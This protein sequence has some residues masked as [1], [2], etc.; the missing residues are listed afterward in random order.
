MISI[1]VPTYNA[2]RYLRQAVESILEQDYLDVELIVVDGK[3]TD[4]TVNIL[5]EYGKEIRWI[6]EKDKGE[7]DAINKGM[8]MA[9]GELIGFLNADDIY[10]PN[11]LSTV[12]EHFKDYPNSMWAY[13]KC[14][15]IDEDGEEARG[16]VTKIKELFQPHY[17]YS[18]LL[19]GDFIAQPAAFWRREL[20][21]EIG[22]FDIRETLAF[23]YDFWLRAGKLYRPGFINEYLAS[24]R[25]HSES[26][27]VNN[28]YKDMKDAYR[29]SKGYSLARPLINLA[30]LGVYLATTSGYFAMN[31]LARTRR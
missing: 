31:T 7:P 30:Q 17:S 12:V 4:S 10:L 29:I 23:E 3:S 19:I 9:K 15:I 25:A 2:E 8:A 21:N 5:R 27:T 13:G 20:V 24:W 14:K 6:S 11:A 22:N 16:L 1:I 18:R 28:I 26:L